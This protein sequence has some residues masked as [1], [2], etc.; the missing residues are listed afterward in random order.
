MCFCT[1][2]EEVRLRRMVLCMAVDGL[3]HLE[4]RRM[5]CNRCKQLRS[6]ERAAQLGGLQG[7]AGARFS[8]CDRMPHAR[9]G[10]QAAVEASSNNDACETEADDLLS[11]PRGAFCKRG[12][13]RIFDIFASS[14]PEAA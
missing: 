9:S 5:T 8:S 12:P 14:I 3:F 6:L 4:S 10:D 11:V 2:E 7:K 1:R 13:P